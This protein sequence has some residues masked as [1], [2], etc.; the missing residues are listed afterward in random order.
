MSCCR[1]VAD[2]HTNIAGTQT[3]AAGCCTSSDSEADRSGCCSS[4]AS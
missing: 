2:E 3:D 1:D 4:S